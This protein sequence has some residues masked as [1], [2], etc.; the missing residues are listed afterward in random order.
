M[1]L[2]RKVTRLAASVLATAMFACATALPA[3]ADFNNGTQQ[4]ISQNTDGKFKIT[5]NLL[6]PKDIASPQVSFTYVIDEGTVTSNEVWPT[7]GVGSANPVAVYPGEEGG[8]IFVAPDPTEPG[9]NIH[10]DGLQDTVTYDTAAPET[11]SE[12]SYTVDK[13][14]TLQAVLQSTAGQSTFTHA[15][16]YKYTL[17]VSKE[18]SNDNGDFTVDNGTRTVYVY[19]GND[20]DNL[21]IEAITMVKPDTTQGFVK[22]EEFNHKYLFDGDGNPD[23]ENQSANLVLSKTVAG[24]YGNKE[25]DFSFKVTVEHNSEAADTQYSYVKGTINALGNFVEPQN[26]E[27]KLLPEDGIIKLKHNEAIKIVGLTENDKYSIS[28]TV[29][30]KY[31]T[32][33]DV[34]LEDT[35][36]DADYIGPGEGTYDVKET[37]GLTSTEITSQNDIQVKYTNTHKEVTPT[38]VIMNVAPYVLM[39]VIAAAGCFVF[40]R[41]RRDD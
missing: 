40:L 4:G 22:N 39:V 12:T 14:L 10:S 30:N 6:V 20:D 27:Y 13:T 24:V 19:V 28:E 36:Y 5:S 25:Q 21:K 8:L 3:M 33:A 38:G 17:N 23:P 35:S 7:T 1:K 29:D 2:N 11:T 41:K 37:T 32:S 9:H 18:G 16:V 34:T 31:T 26:P 15:G